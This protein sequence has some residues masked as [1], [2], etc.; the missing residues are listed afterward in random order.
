MGI[1]DIE[2]TK[3][4]RHIGMLDIEKADGEEKTK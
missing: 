2:Q 3:N 4:S 1:S